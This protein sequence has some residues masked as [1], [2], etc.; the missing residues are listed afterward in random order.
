MLIYVWFI[1]KVQ[2][3]RANTTVSNFKSQKQNSVKSFL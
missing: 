1:L 2:K 3:Q